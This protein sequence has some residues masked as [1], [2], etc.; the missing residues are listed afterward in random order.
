MM[1]FMS[2]NKTL[3]RRTE[4]TIETHQLTRITGGSVAVRC[5]ACGGTM[6]VSAGEVYPMLTTNGERNNENTDDDYIGDIG[7]GNLE[8]WSKQGRAG[9]SKN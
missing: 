1:A 6:K 4:I 8:L 2:M 7:H 3:H 9:T 5:E